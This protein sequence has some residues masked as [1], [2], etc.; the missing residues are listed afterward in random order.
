MIPSNQGFAVPPKEKLREEMKRRLKEAKREGF[1]RQGAASAAL[2]RASPIWPCYAT[3]LLFLSMDYEIDTRPLLEAA[4]IDGKK[5]FAPK[6]SGQ[7]LIFYN[8]TS[9]EGPWEKGAFGIRE[10]VSSPAAFG[11]IPALIVVPGLAFDQSGNR[12]GKGGGY[13]DRFLGE[14]DA[15]GRRYASLARRMDFQ[16]VGSGP[17]EE[18]DR[19]MNCVL[20]QDELI[21]I[22]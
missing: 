8:V 10:P 5:V 20:T 14:L 6:V 16:I 4:L 15:E 9:A 3:I 13:Y 17:T 22:S 7:T 11:D 1:K 19:K 12:L 18:K 2:L 21:I